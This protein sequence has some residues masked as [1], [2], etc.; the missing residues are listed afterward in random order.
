MLRIVE[1][2]EWDNIE[3]GLGP[4]TNS[5]ACRVPIAPDCGAAGNTDIGSML[6]FVRR[7]SFQSQWLYRCHD[8]AVLEL[9][10]FPRNAKSICD[11]D[12]YLLLV[13]SNLSQITSFL[14]LRLAGQCWRFPR[15]WLFVWTDGCF[16][17]IF[18]LV[19]RGCLFP[20]WLGVFMDFRKQI[21][22]PI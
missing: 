21:F 20:A 3:A 4:D 10:H 6:R 1:V 2:G 22:S 16:W 9:S 12:A 11:Q 13:I 15:V 8:I 17:N 14:R 18:R 7:A 5:A 19:L